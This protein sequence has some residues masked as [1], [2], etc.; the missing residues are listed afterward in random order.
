MGGGCARTHGTE[1]ANGT[2]VWGGARCAVAL[3]S[4][5]GELGCLSVS[6]TFQLAGAWK[7]TTFDEAGQLDPESRSAVD[8]EKIA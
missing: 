8:S 2:G 7:P 5:L 1:G 4:Y 3:R 6:S